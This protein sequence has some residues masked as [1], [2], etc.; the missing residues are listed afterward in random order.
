MKVYVAGASAEIERAER[1]IALA[2]TYGA[3][4]TH[5]WTIDVRKEGGSVP[6]SDVDPATFA[7]R[8]I[9]A[10]LE[11]DAVV[12]LVPHQD[13][14]TKGLWVEL[15]ALFG[16]DRTRYEPR[17]PDVCISK[18][19]DFKHEHPPQPETIWHAYAFRQLDA[20]VVEVDQEAIRWLRSMA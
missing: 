10:V 7:A 16:M 17:R 11:A 3:E 2:K 15:G 6:A 14:A 20:T 12:F 9:S 4:I 5:D 18:A 13:H 8:D 19:R 1:F